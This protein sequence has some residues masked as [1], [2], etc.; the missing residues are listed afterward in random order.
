VRSGERSAPEWWRRGRWVASGPEGQQAD[1]QR[2]SLP[3]APTLSTAPTAP[4]PNCLQLFEAA[5]NS[6]LQLSE[7]T[8]NGLQAVQTVYYTL[9]ALCTALCNGVRLTT[10]PCHRLTAA[11]RSAGRGGAH[12]RQRLG[13]HQRERKGQRHLGAQGGGGGGG[14]GGGRP[15][16]PPPRAPPG[17]RAWGGGGA[18]GTSMT[19]WRGS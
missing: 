2:P 1:D 10:S 5:A 3:A 6:C 18:G 7:A 15:P 9:T 19:P 11:R 17:P 13:H 14:G 12:L 16:P 4:H 8:R